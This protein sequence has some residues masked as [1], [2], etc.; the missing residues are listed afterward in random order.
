MTYQEEYILEKKCLLYVFHNRK[1]LFIQCHLHDIVINDLLVIF[2]LKFTHYYKEYNMALNRRDFFKWSA[3]STLT[4]LTIANG[5][6]HEGV[7]AIPD[8]NNLQNITKEM[9]NEIMKS[10]E[11]YRT[12]KDNTYFK[13]IIDSQK[14]RATIVGCCD[15]RFQVSTIDSTPENDL[16]VIRNIGNQ[17]AINEGSITYGVT[18]LKTPLLIIVGH[19]RCGAIK[20]AMS[21]YSNEDTSIRREIDALSLSIKKASLKEN[22]IENWLN[23]VVKNTNQQVQYATNKFSKE[24]INGQLTIIGL[25]YDFANDFGKGYGKIHIT[26]ING[27][28]NHAEISKN[29]LIKA[30]L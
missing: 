9:F 22:E 20:A 26:S 10:N 12:K 6:T 30:L 18:H 14:P 16:F 4:T 23:A 21:D 29:P 7:H 15:S 5:S 25:V 28:T 3:V 11:Y 17:F 13:S 8:V 19:T 2:I 24:V 1:Q 27:E